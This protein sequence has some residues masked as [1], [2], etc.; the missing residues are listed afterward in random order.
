MFTVFKR[1]PI[2]LH[3]HADL[4]LLGRAIDHVG[5]DID[6]DIEGHAG[7]GIGLD[8]L[9]SRWPAVRNGEGEYGAF[10]G[11]LTPFDVA[12]SAGEDAYRAR[13]VLVLLCRF[14]VLDD[15][16]FLPCGLPERHAK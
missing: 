11:D 15:E 10:A 1:M 3:L 7:D 8:T 16:L 4:Q 14:A 6:T 5:D 2:R 9:K 12:A 13:E